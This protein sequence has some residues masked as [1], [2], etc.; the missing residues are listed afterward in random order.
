MRMVNWAASAPKAP[1]DEIDANAP[2]PMSGSPR[3]SIENDVTRP[4]P[5]QIRPI[6]CPGR[7]TR[8]NVPTAEADI[9]S[10]GCHSRSSPTGT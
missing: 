7:L 4:A 1:P 10:N 8:M 9:A 6:P 5:R 3:A 2:P